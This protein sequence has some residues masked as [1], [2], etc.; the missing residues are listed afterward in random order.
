MTKVLAAI[1]TLAL[2]LSA[3]LI[4]A[5]P[6]AAFPYSEVWRTN[7][8]AQGT[9]L[10]NFRANYPQ[11]YNSALVNGNVAWTGARN[12]YGVSFG[13]P[14]VNGVKIRA[15]LWCEKSGN[16]RT[17]LDIS[18]WS[19]FITREGTHDVAQSR[20]A[21]LSRFVGC[22]PDSYNILYN[23]EYATDYGYRYKDQRTTNYVLGL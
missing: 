21:P 1:S 11:A 3:F 13:D 18:P 9:H 12:G 14:V 17:Q 8:T 20:V 16:R 10:G 6:A 22:R 15:S 23:F 2:L 7:Y 4:T 19:I 5:S